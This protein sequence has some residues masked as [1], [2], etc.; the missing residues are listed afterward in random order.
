[1]TLTDGLC[2]VRV[3]EEIH[4][5]NEER[6]EINDTRPLRSLV[7]VT[8]SVDGIGI[9]CNHYE[10]LRL[11]ITILQCSYHSLVVVAVVYTNGMLIFVALP[12][13]LLW[14]DQSSQIK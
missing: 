3:N 1:M 14:G 13:A 11:K 8:V 4:E 9:L 5:E 7:I 12:N 10:E 2:H 6:A